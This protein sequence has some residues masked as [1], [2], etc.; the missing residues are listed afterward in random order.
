MQPGFFRFIAAVVAAVVLMMVASCRTPE[1]SEAPGD[2]ALRVRV[3]RLDRRLRH[4]EAELTELLRK[5]ME[6]CR[7]M[8]EGR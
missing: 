1:A 4:V 2:E 3:D 7:K 5:E 6:E 8:R